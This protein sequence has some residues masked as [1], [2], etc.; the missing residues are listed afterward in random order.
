MKYYP[1][2]NIEIFNKPLNNEYFMESKGPVFFFVAQ[3]NLN[4]C[5]PG[6]LTFQPWWNGH[7]FL[8]WMYT[9]S[10]IAG[11][12]KGLLTIGFP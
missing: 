5:T 7:F 12:I 8:P 6:S 1:V 3:F 4:T 9:P 10:E 2:I 11:L